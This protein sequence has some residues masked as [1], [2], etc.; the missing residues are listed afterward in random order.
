[1]PCTL[2]HSQTAQH[3][4]WLDQLQGQLQVADEEMAQAK[5]HSDSLDRQL[6]ESEVRRAACLCC[7]GLGRLR[8]GTG[9]QMLI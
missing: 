7:R 3:K 8:W 1:M 9:F 2:P 4:A 6:E 5:L